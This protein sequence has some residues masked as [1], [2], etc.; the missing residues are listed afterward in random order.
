MNLVARAFANKQAT[1][2]RKD[3]KNLFTLAV[4]YPLPTQLGTV[5]GLYNSEGHCKKL[6]CK[7]CNGL[8]YDPLFDTKVQLYCPWCHAIHFIAESET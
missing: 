5:P 4:H 8:F 1:K 3:S 7:R 2:T 6:R